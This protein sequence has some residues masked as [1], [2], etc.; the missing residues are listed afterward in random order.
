MGEDHGFDSHMESMDC[1]VMGRKTFD[2]VKDMDDWIYDKPV[3]VLSR[4]LVPNKISGSLRQK[5]DDGWPRV[6]GLSGQPGDIM[7]EVR[8]RGWKRVYVDGGE[9]IRSFL[10]EGLVESMVISRVPVLIGQGVPLFGEL[11]RDVKLVHKGT[12]SWASGVVQS[13]YRVLKDSEGKEVVS[14]TNFRHE[15]EE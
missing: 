13:R 8:R 14:E 11:G 1:V 15:I 2:A 12:T 7:A 4:T 3:L 9:V 6:E 10:N 5:T